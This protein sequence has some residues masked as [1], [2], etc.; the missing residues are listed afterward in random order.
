M[1]QGVI[2]LWREVEYYKDYQKKL[3]EYAGEEKANEII[4]EA[5]YLVSIGTNDFLENYYIFPDRQSQF[6]VRQYEDFL[7]GIARNFIQDLYGLGARKIALAGLPP[8]GCLPLERA[9]NIMDFH[10]CVEGYNNLA[11]EFNGK[12]EGMVAKLNKELPGLNMEFADVYNILLQ[13]IRRPSTYGK[14][15][16]TFLSLILPFSHHA[17]NNLLTLK[18]GMNTL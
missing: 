4:R 7:I 12:L 14:F 1:F 6:T 2:P 10:G 9:T 5:L 15:G 16:W 11:L 17:I 3:K 13:I 18:P 8:M